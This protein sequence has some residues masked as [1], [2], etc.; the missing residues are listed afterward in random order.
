MSD[1]SWAR[2]YRDEISCATLGY[3]YGI[4]NC[5]CTL[6]WIKG[7]TERDVPLLVLMLVTTFP[8]TGCYTAMTEFVALLS[9]DDGKKQERFDSLFRTS[10]LIGFVQFI[11]MIRF[12]LLG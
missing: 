11:L 4:I 1:L 10:T 6:L 12:F 3:G 9:K 7:V 8:V 2:Q 5:T